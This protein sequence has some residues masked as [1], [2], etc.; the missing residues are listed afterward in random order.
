MNKTDIDIPL[1]SVIF[2][3]TVVFREYV[4]KHVRCCEKIQVIISKRLLL[5]F[6]DYHF[7]LTITKKANSENY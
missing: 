3:F 1:V 5:R 7:F 2:C 4:H 6:Y